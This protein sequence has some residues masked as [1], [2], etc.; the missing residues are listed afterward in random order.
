ME[1]KEYIISTRLSNREFYGIK[2]E[3]GDENIVLEIIMDKVNSKIYGIE[4]KDAAALAF[5]VGLHIDRK[6][7][8][9]LKSQLD[10]IS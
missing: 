7:M 3:E 2:Y 5:Q 4:F 9:L 8:K 10:C 1:N 6:R